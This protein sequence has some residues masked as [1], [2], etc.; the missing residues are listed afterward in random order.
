M[1]IDMVRHGVYIDWR[2]PVVLM[3]LSTAGAIAGAMLRIRSFMILGITF[4]VIDIVT[5]IWY[6][7]E[8]LE[9]TWVWSASGIVLGVAI[10]T[11]FVIFEKRRHDLLAAMQ[12]F[13]EWER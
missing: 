10:I 8:D 2:L 7:A 12:R 5:M 13:K 9:Q 1:F 3:L 6:A 11:F 4:L